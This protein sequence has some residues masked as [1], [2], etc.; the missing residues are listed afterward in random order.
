MN[1]VDGRQCAEVVDIRRNNAHAG[2]SGQEGHHQENARVDSQEP[3]ERPGERGQAQ[4]HRFAGSP[5]W[6]TSRPILLVLGSC[7]WVPPC[8]RHL[9]DVGI[10][11][12]PHQR[13]GTG[14]TGKLR[15]PAA[16]T[17][18]TA[19]I[20]LSF[21]SFSVARVTLPNFWTCSH[22]GLLVP[23]HNTSYSVANPPGEASQVSVESFSKSF[24]SRCTF[25]G[26][27]GAAANDARVAA[28]NRATCAT[29]S[30]STNFKVSPYSMPFSVRTF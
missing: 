29:Y 14:T 28:F 19:K 7:R 16:S 22:S 15:C 30:K 13:C 20:T 2:K 21:E 24:A 8:S 26:G 3:G 4:R 27:A 12:N 18:R 17:A 1:Y 23:R 11:L 9:G 10:F 6:S 25:A 5:H